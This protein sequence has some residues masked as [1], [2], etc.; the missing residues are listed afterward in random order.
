MS[1]E[2]HRQITQQTDHTNPR[3]TSE[4]SPRRERTREEADEGKSSCLGFILTNDYN[5]VYYRYKIL[6]F[7]R[8]I[9]SEISLDQQILRKI[10]VTG[11]WVYK[12]Y[13]KIVKI[14]N[15]GS[16]PLFQRIHILE[17]TE[18]QTVEDLQSKFIGNYYTQSKEYGD[19]NQED[20]KSETS[21]LRGH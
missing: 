10:N 16:P 15:G 14:S 1:P 21:S 5:L 8:Q 18:R 9:F 3:R 19:L 11:C 20:R 7:S 6:S 13:N 17:P 12:S 2:T 4:A